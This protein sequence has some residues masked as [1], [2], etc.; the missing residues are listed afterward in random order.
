[1]RSSIARA[2]TKPTIRIDSFEIRNDRFHIKNVTFSYTSTMTLWSAKKLLWLVLCGNYCLRTAYSALITPKRGAVRVSSRFSNHY[3]YSDIHEGHSCRTVLRGF[4]AKGVHPC[5]IHAS[6]TASAVLEESG[7]P[8]NRLHFVHDFAA[9]F[10]HI[11][12]NYLEIFWTYSFSKTMTY[13]LPVCFLLAACR[14]YSPELG[15]FL[16]QSLEQMLGAI[17]WITS[18]VGRI[19]LLPL[20][21]G[22]AVLNALPA[23]IV[24]LLEYM[25]PWVVV[26]FVSPI[27]YIH[28]TLH[29]LRSWFLLSTLAISVWRPIL[30]EIQYRFLVTKIV[31][32]ERLGQSFGVAK[33][34][35]VEPLVLLEESPV[36]NQSTNTTSMSNSMSRSALLSS[37]L[38]AA[39][40]LGWLCTSPDNLS[41][42]P[43]AWTVGFCQSVLG[44]LS[45]NAMSELRPLLH[46]GLTFL[47]L[48]QSITTFLLSI[49]IYVPF[50]NERGIFASIGA[51]VAWTTG[52]IT[53]PFRMARR[54]YLRFRN[55]KSLQ[56]QST[57][58]T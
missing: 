44:H 35:M 3:R 47:A 21:A 24:P 28:N 51:H 17:F 58:R 18:W 56:S 11:S 27:L 50:Y 53:I 9:G 54:L 33:S 46:S 30:E 38:F 34:S 5:R 20:A 22:A 49:N 4:T 52:I 12:S 48:H 10:Q 7:N 37:F 31:G 57:G 23:I 14:I 6:T 55:A 25:P 8:N 19:L 39:T 29:S 43:Y 42:S 32:E 36:T 16:S 26:T 2:K 45:S 1:M 40:R 15:F 13:L 41:P